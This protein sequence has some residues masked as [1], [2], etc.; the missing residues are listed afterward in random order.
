MSK[1]KHIVY[2]Q[3]RRKKIYNLIVLVFIMLFI[4]GCS[5]PRK[6][7]YLST[8]QS[9][10]LLF[11]REYSVKYPDHWDMYMLYLHNFAFENFISIT[12]CTY[13]QDIA[14]CFYINNGAD[15]VCQWFYN[16][17]FCCKEDS[18]NDNYDEYYKKLSRQV[19]LDI[20][21]Y[22]DEY[23]HRLDDKESG[24]IKKYD[25]V[26]KYKD[27]VILF[28][29]FKVDLDLCYCKTPELLFFN[30][31]KIERQVSIKKVIS[32]EEINNDE[33]SNFEILFNK[34]YKGS[35]GKEKKNVN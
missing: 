33:Q 15:Y 23:G 1:I 28:I 35:V 19:R 18:L 21:K 8:N 3:L 12:K 13:L 14:E 6:K 26:L 27:I 16:L 5:L 22:F 4:F 25:I 32:I 29:I 2:S 7:K 30:G 17:S 20:G 31:V 9:N 10:Y 24:V 11:A 34:I